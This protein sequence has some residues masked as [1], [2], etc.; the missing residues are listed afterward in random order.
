[1][2]TLTGRIALVSLLASAAASA[3][4]EVAALRSRYDPSVLAILDA[5]ASAARAYASTYVAAPPDTED[6]RKVVRIGLVRLGEWR[7]RRVHVYARIE[8][9]AGRLSISGVEG[10]NAFG[11][12]AGGAGQIDIGVP[13]Y[14]E[15]GQYAYGW[16]GETL[17]RL[18]SIWRRY[19]LNDMRAGTVAQSEFLRLA[20][21]ALP[22]R[23]AG[24][25]YDATR[26][27]LR[28][29]D[30]YVDSG[31]EYGSKWLNE[32]VPSTALDFL[33]ALPAA[34]RDCW[35]SL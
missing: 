8:Y 9:S 27:M 25:S 6:F 21:A 13:G 35:Y 22:P 17:A 29:V 2:I 12:C 32:D 1:M 3:A 26:D 7:K 18:A 28:A 20:R 16:D 15:G 11:N 34:D 30:L 23:Y 14:M 10:P 4:A 5:S 31:Y 19:H 33:R 24:A